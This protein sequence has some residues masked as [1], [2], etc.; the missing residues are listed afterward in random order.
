MAVAVASLVATVLL[1]GL[2]FKLLRGQVEQREDLRQTQSRLDES[3]ARIKQFLAERP[4]TRKA[5]ARAAGRRADHSAAYRRVAQR[6]EELIA[7]GDEKRRKLA[8]LAMNDFT[9]FDRLDAEV[10]QDERKARNRDD[11]E[12]YLQRGDRWYRAQ[13]FDKAIELYDK[14][15]ALRPDDF[16]ARSG[17]VAAQISAPL[18]NIADHQRRAIEVAEG[19]LKIVSPGSKEWA[20]MQH[21]MGGAWLYMP[22]GD[23]TENLRKAIARF[24]A[25]L[26]VY[27]KSADPA[28][29]AG[30]QNNLGMAWWSM[31]TGDKVENLRKA[32]TYFEAALTAYNKA[33]DSADWAMMQNNLGNVWKDMPTGGKAENLR[34]AIACYEEA[35][36]AHAKSAEPKRWATIQNNLGIA[37]RNMP[38]G[39]KCEKPPQGHRLL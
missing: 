8:A 3:V 10:E 21:N 18:G 1:A 11:F 20:E 31:P 13:D 27:T 30:A 33:T 16:T 17:L 39:D 7:T 32:I 12:R 5:G 22:T 37:W 24:E 35:L 14:A 9:T 34:N 29:W 6:A 2:M 15:I 26:T 38:T 4:W 23:K 36:G 19:T 25:A 28:H